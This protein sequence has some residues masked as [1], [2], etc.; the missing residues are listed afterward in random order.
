MARPMRTFKDWCLPFSFLL[1]VKDSDVVVFCRT[2]D[3]VRVDEL[4]AALLVP[5]RRSI[6]DVPTPTNPGF[7]RCC[8][9]DCWHN[10]RDD[11]SLRGMYE[12]YW[13]K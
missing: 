4:V 9:S 1:N 13:A 10:S 7:P 8:Q 3:Q 11:A 6:D 12:I 2:A 5:G